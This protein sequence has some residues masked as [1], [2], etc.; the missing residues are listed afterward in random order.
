MK[1]KLALIL[2]ALM[3]TVPRLFRA[4]ARTPS[5]SVTVIDA[6]TGSSRSV[7]YSNDTQILSAL[8]SMVRGSKG[9]VIVDKRMQRIDTGQMVDPARPFWSLPP[10]LRGFFAL[11]MNNN[12]N[13]GET[14]LPPNT[15]ALWLTGNTAVDW[16]LWWPGRN[17]F[18]LTDLEKGVM[19]LLKA[20]YE[21]RTHLAA[22][23][24]SS[25]YA[26]WLEVIDAIP[27]LLPI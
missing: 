23:S 15:E 24:K 18:G 10:A 17:L 4:V 13:A 11:E 22:I 16:A 26:N 27:P 7:T 14:A 12:V 21:R 3:A 5:K 9:T 8:R 2:G 19:A 25:L 6:A 1:L 20:E